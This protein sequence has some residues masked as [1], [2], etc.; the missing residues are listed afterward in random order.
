MKYKNKKTGEIIDTECKIEG[1]KWE[2]VEDKEKKAS[3]KNEETK[4]SSDTE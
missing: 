2:K 4:E 1:G 3:K